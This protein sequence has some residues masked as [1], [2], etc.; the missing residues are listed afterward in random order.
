[1]SIT[2]RSLPLKGC[3][4][5]NWY[6]SEKGKSSCAK[7]GGYR[8]NAGHSKKFKVTD[9]FCNVVTL[10]STYELKC[11]EILNDLSIRW[12][13]PKALKYDGKNYFADFYLVDYDLYL[14]PKN[15]YKAKCDEEK[16]NKVVEQNKVKVIILLYNDLTHDFIAGLAEKD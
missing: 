6:S 13:R 5:K 15:N 14:D 10:Q 12:I 3:F 9:S 8:E 16:I 7:G 1:M 2:I 4:A 11:S